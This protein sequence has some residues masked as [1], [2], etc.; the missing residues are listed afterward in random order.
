[1][2]VALGVK[3]GASSCSMWARTK[4]KLLGEGVQS[5]VS[6]NEDADNGVNASQVGAGNASTEG[7]LLPQIGH[8]LD[9]SISMEHSLHHA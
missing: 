4:K 7:K 5:G 2:A 1:M 8:S 6:K 3:N 9:P